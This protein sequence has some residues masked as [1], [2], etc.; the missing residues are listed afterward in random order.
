M[1]LSSPMVTVAPVAPITL[2]PTN[3]GPYLLDETGSFVGQ[4]LLDSVLARREKRPHLSRSSSRL[5]R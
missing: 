5:V 1:S 4:L 2:R 3:I